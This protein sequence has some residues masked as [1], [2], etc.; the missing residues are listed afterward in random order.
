MPSI[1]EREPWED[2]SERMKRDKEQWETIGVPWCERENAERRIASA[3]GALNYIR[4]VLRS[5]I[6]QRPR[7]Q[8]QFLREIV[9]IVELGLAPPGWRETIEKEY[10][11]FAPRL[12]WVLHHDVDGKTRKLVQ[13]GETQALT[14]EQRGLVTDHLPLVRKYA[15]QRASK[16]NNVTGGTVLDQELFAELEQREAAQ[17]E[18]EAEERAELAKAGADRARTAAGPVSGTG[19]P[20]VT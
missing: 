16:I 5:A 18:A 15:D 12:D 3:G 2:M 10:P 8:E 17:A 1:S 6:G 19:S 11:N 20:A 4:G 13:T 7:V 14:K 9:P